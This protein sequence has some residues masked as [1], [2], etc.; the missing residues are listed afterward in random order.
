MLS[1][2]FQESFMNSSDPEVCSEHVPAVWPSYETAEDLPLH[3]RV[4]DWVLEDAKK[5]WEVRR[6]NIYVAFSIAL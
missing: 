1:A 4:K 5:A 3:P 6:G 2:S